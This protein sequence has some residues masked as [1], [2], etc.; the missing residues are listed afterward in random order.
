MGVTP[1]VLITSPLAGENISG[2]VQ[3]RGTFTGPANT[4]ITV[5]GALIRFDGVR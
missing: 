4:G 5:S 3:V 1:T 2:G